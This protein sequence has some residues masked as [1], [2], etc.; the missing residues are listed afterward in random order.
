MLYEINFYQIYDCNIMYI[1]FLWNNL[2]SYLVQQSATLKG[3]RQVK[4][5]ALFQEH[6]LPS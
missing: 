4:K 6:E 5:G 3:S 2:F 1:S